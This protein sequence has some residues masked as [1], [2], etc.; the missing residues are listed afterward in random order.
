M[1]A[2]APVSVRISIGEI[3][4]AAPKHIRHTTDLGLRSIADRRTR[5]NGLL[6]QTTILIVETV[7]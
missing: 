6:R 2:A 4:N 5:R 1:Q 7:P 3:Y